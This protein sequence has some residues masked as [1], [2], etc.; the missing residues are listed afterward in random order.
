MT[1]PPNSLPLRELPTTSLYFQDSLLGAGFWSDWESCRSGPFSFRFGARL[2]IVR[3]A[4]EAEVELAR[5][6]RAGGGR[7]I[8]LIDDDL[9]AIV[10]DP[11][12]PEDY[13]GRIGAFLSGPWQYLKEHIDEVV[14]GSDTLS[15]KMRQVGF[16]RV[17]QMDPLW[18][19]PSEKIPSLA[20]RETPLEIAW[21]CSRSH[22][23]DLDSISAQL[24]KFLSRHRNVK[25][26]VFFGKNKPKWIRGLR[27]VENLKPLD[28]LEY[29]LWIQ[30]K[31]YDLALYPLLD[32]GVNQCRSINKF[33][34][35]A[36]IGAASI[37][38]TNAPFASR[39]R[40]GD[41]LFA[42]PG[43]WVDCLEM[44]LAERGQ[45]GDLANQAREHA[46]I[47]S[48]EA[49]A[50]QIEFWKKRLPV[51]NIDNSAPGVRV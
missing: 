45:I 44:L 17:T 46:R 5:T 25:L 13:R 35:H 12:L 10:D 6:I 33:L 8:Y 49:R 51:L 48:S 7:V 32:N 43:T 26:T 1:Q 2:V 38:S 14:V 30:S 50:R 18:S 39:L 23:A 47:I 24:T 3:Y 40:S 27:Q 15:K 19:I 20:G 21:L 28:W 41:C 16:D 11:Q 9:Q 37:I 22:A 29:R 4:T 42:E 31:H 34:E 36:V